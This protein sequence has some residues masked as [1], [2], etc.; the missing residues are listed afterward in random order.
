MKPV[1][2]CA[3]IALAVIPATPFNTAV[4]SALTGNGMDHSQSRHSRPRCLSP[5]RART[6]AAMALRWLCAIH[7]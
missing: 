7:S 6:Q 5:T 1:V 3:F 4:T 2:C